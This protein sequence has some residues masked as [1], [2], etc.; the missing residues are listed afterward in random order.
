MDS[1]LVTTLR[2]REKV[3]YNLLSKIQPLKQIKEALFH[4]SEQSLPT[5]F[6]HVPDR[7]LDFGIS[8][9]IKIEALKL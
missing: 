6:P 7:T 8:G 1:R 3:K 5:F 9:M 2:A 4:I